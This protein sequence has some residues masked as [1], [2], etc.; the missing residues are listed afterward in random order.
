MNK[1]TVHYISF[2]ALFLC[3]TLLCS[4]LMRVWT[5][6]AQTR[7][8]QAT[9]L[10]GTVI[11]LD[12]GHGG[13]DG[14]AE[15]TNGI[16]EKELNLA[17]TNALADL[18]R[19][20]GYTVVQTRTDDRLLCDADTPK[21][22]RKQS[23]LANRLAVTA[24]YESCVLISIHMNTFPDQSCT[25]TQVWYSAGHEASASLAQAVQDRVRT[26][27]QPSNHRKIKAATSGIYLLRHARV[28]AI[29]I[30]CG[31]LSTPTECEKLCDPA[32]QHRLATAIF[33][34]ICENIRLR[35]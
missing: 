21:G 28:P 18:L 24:R 5:M 15:G 14:G 2:G 17:L 1:Q 16:A 32:Y 31:F 33:T 10:G 27:L 20:A 12:A 4:S 3:V 6:Q 35:P 26:L 30:E 13:E 8:T 25:G 7:T 11:V 22:H 29:L 23:D 19:L 34:A 9:E